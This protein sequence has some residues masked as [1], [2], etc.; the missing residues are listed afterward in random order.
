MLRL[1]GILVLGNMIFGDTRH[2]RNGGFPGLLFILPVLLF[3]GWIALAVAGG[4]LGLAGIAVGSV[5]S[6]LSSLA[7][8]AFSGAG[9]A[10]GIVIGMAAFYYF[11][12]RKRAENA[13]AAE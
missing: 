1:L 4:I 8:S 3:G 9:L 6:G 12:N 11:R 10:V 2:R 13:E 7:S 5:I